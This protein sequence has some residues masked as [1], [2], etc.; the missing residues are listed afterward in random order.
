MIFRLVD[1]VVWGTIILFSSLFQTVYYKRGETELIERECMERCED[2]ATV[3]VKFGSSQFG[4]AMKQCCKTDY[5][6][7]VSNTAT[8]ILPQLFHVIIMM[9]VTLYVNCMK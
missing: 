8:S 3:P 9:S 2:G 6:N 5:C 7:I 4:Q 1:C